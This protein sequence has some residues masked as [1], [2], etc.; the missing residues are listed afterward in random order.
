[1]TLP[2]PV[3]RP[4]VNGKEVGMRVVEGEVG[5]HVAWEE[6]KNSKICILIMSVRYEYSSLICTLGGTNVAWERWF[7][8]YIYIYIL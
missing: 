1:M 2:A 8:I 7:D 3:L 6:E 5:T 4:H